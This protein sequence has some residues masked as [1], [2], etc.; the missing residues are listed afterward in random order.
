MPLEYSEIMAYLT[1]I[2]II[3][4]A[5]IIGYLFQVILLSRLAK[6]ASKTR[7]QG[8]EI[9]I[10]SLRGVIVLWSF[11]IG[12]YIALPFVT[13]PEYLLNILQKAVLVIVIFSITVVAAKMAAGFVKMYAERSKG[14]FPSTTLF[15]NIAKV[16]IFIVGTLV[17]LQTLGIHIT[18]ILTALGVGGL[19]VAL[20]LQDT[21][22]NLFAGIHI[23]AA[24]KV[25]PGDYVKLESGE[26]GYVMD[27]SWRNT[28][29]RALPNNI[30][31][32]PNNKLAGAILTNFHLPGSEMSVVLQ[33]GVSYDS[34]LEKVEKV[35]KEVASEIV[36]NVEGGVREWDP[37]IRYHT[38]DNSSINFSVIL[39]ATEYVNQYL[40][41]HEFVKKLHERY[42]KEGI[43]IPFPIRTIYMKNKMLKHSD[44]KD[45]L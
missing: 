39:R 34:D 26:E 16:V 7:W 14:A 23:I 2:I 1:P 22:S 40:L 5:I 20:A 45:Q 41:K 3:L 38:F 15:T 35:T 13:L 42:N 29:V 24:G 32:I 19:A 30:I 36:K 25:R 17:I 18:P 27:I 9:I 28:T 37:F 6:V 8:D 31:I 33:V 44:D 10:N 43:E 12:V 11:I 4:S 21:L